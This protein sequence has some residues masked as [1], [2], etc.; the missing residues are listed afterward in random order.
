M[1]NIALARAKAFD[2][3]DCSIQYARSYLLHVDCRVL[4]VL[5]NR[6]RSSKI[7]TKRN[8]VAAAPNSVGVTWLR[9]KA[10]DQIQN[11]LKLAYAGS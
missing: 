7:Q 2:N 9:E 4:E 10:V 6:S 11:T 8:P 5:S 1:L 3:I